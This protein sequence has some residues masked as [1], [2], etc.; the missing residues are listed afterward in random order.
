MENQLL[1]GYCCTVKMQV[2]VAFHL[3]R[4]KKKKNQPLGSAMEKGGR[5]ALLPRA[6]RARPVCW[7]QLAGDC[8]KQQMT[9]REP[10][11]KWDSQTA[12]N[13]VPVT[14]GQFCWLC[15]LPH[16]DLFVNDITVSSMWTPNFHS[17]YIASQYSDF[18]DEANISKTRK[19]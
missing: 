10:I 8:Q 9:D 19:N 15:G 16:M 12:G 2:P 18:L 14:R 1:S 4:K 17:L 7:G 5:Q 11:Q 6:A 13:R 3:G